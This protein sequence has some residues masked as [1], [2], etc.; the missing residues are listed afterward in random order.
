MTSAEKI[1]IKIEEILSFFKLFILNQVVFKYLFEIREGY[2]PFP[3]QK[4]V[5]A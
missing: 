5:H 4:I 2:T 3:S 1:D